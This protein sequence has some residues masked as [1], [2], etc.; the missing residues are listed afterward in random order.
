MPK[1][2]ADQKIRLTFL[3]TRPVDPTAPTVTELDAG[4]DLS[5]SIMKSDYQLGATGDQTISEAAL[6][7]PGAGNDMGATDY[8]ASVTVFRMLDDEGKADLEEDTGF[9][10]LK[11][12]GT[13]GWLVE[14]EGPRYDVD[15]ADGQEVETYEVTT[16]SVQKPSDRSAGYIK[17]TIPMG[18]QNAWT[19]G[20]V[21]SA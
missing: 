17:R 13:K 16:G 11:V 8:A 14:R 18:V 2:L 21:A 9:Q 4:V 20:V 15:W 12:K 3:T 6:C 1:T 5:C 19:T 7:E 10:A